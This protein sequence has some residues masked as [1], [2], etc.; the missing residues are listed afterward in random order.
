MKSLYESILDSEEKIVSQSMKKFG[1]VAEMRFLDM[2]NDAYTDV[3]I[4]RYFKWN[5]VKMY[6]KKNNIT[7]LKGWRGGQGYDVGEI[8]AI[9]NSVQFL[10][11]EQNFL[12]LMRE[13]LKARFRM[14]LIERN[15]LSTG[16]QLIYKITKGN[17]DPEDTMEITMTVR[18]KS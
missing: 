12:V 18:Q 9:L 11:Y 1:D 7:P 8:P 17:G 2:H 10:G 6:C 16:T 4:A 5:D 14:E 3:N 13:F 15:T